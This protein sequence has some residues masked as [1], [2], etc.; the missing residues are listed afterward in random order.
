MP[1]KKPIT[2]AEAAKVVP[3]RRK[4]VAKGKPHQSVFAMPFATPK[5]SKS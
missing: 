2:I 5:K 1:K 3:F 4:P